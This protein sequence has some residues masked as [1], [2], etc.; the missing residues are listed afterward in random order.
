MIGSVSGALYWDLAVIKS[1]F[2]SVDIDGRM[3]SFQA[4]RQTVP[5]MTNESLFNCVVGGALF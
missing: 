2:A 3:G 1:N 4:T 5:I